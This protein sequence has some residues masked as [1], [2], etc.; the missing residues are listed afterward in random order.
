MTHTV[1]KIGGTSMSRTDELLD[2]LLIGDRE[3]ADLYG[4][5][6]VVSAYG[7]MTD[8]L[9]ENK[10]TGAP[11]VFGAFAG[12]DGAGAWMT[13]LDEAS[14]AMIDMNGRLIEDP[15]DRAAADHFVRERIEG[16]R[17]CLI[18]LGRLCSYGHFKLDEH[19]MTVRELL[20][21]LGEAHSAHNTALL[22]R[23]RG[24]N[25]RFVDLSG[26]RDEGSP[27][28]EQRIN[29]AFEGIDLAREMPIV[30]GYAQCREGLVSTFDRGYSEVTFSRIAAQTG[31]REAVIHKEFHLSSAD[32]KIVGHENVRKIG[33]TNYD[34]ADQ[35]SN[36][37]MEAIHPRAAKTLRQAG[38]PLRVA[39][40]FEPHDPGTVIDA[41]LGGPSRVEMV[42]GLDVTE[43]EVFEQDM[44]G[45]KGYDAEILKALTRH[46]LWIVAKS[47]NANTITHYVQGPLD[48]VKRVA[49]DVEEAFPSSRVRARRLG[50]V[51]AIGRELHGL[52]PLRRALTA[53]DDAGIEVSAAQENGRGVD[54]MLMVPCDRREDA[55]RALHAELVE[56]A[57]EAPTE[58]EVPLETAA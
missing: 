3:G 51:S 25:G 34:V 12:E 43:L 7:G 57:A 28:L 2:T 26:W 49:V 58:A 38:I 21:G 15:A 42:T 29:D 5:V 33:Q 54:I 40:A 23:R 47:S 32:P 16:A 53:L 39:N 37:G 44:V 19:L 46:K 4:R 20:S 55:I 9:L 52:G 10:K 27:D 18:D 1:E 22:L 17:N 36:L 48:R 8:R 35:L 45:V 31:A 50:L 30:T 41:E 56:K 6:F 24:V 11:G 13:A 14:A